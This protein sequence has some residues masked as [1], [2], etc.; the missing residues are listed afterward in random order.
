MKNKYLKNV[1]T[2]KLDSDKCVGCGRCIEV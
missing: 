1:C 2:L